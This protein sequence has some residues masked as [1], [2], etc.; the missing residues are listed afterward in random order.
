MGMGITAGRLDL[1]RDRSLLSLAACITGYLQMGKGIVA[2][3]RL[4][5]A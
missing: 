2:G 1:L 5:G 4:R 3:D